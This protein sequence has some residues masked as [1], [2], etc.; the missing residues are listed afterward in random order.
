MV[1]KR[2]A[3]LG[4]VI[5]TLLISTVAFAGSARNDDD[6]YSA[7]FS[8]SSNGYSYADTYVKGDSGADANVS[9][10]LRGSGRKLASDEQGG[11]GPINIHAASTNTYCNYYIHGSYQTLQ[12]T[13]MN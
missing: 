7:G 5:M 6:H 3:V 11:N 12:G 10:R 13:F 4:A 8:R 2:V 9:I 1:K